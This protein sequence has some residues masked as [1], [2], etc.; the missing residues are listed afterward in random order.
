MQ[1]FKDVANNNQ[2]KYGNIRK[3]LYLITGQQ[4]KKKTPINAVSPLITNNPNKTLW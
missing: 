1:P 4:S 3:L 2:I